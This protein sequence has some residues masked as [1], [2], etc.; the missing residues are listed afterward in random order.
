M[1]AGCGEED[2]TL[3]Y[4]LVYEGGKGVMGLS[5]KACAFLVVPSGLSNTKS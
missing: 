1:A 4:A 2:C 3:R 5:G